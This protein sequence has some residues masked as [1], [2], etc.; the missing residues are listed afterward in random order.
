MKV[1]LVRLILFLVSACA[2]IPYAAHAADPNG[3]LYIA[4]AVP[5]RNISSTTNPEYPVDI[6]IGGHCVVQGLTFGEIR[7][8][9][10][11]PA[12]TYSASIS[13]ADSANPCGAAS[14]TGSVT[15]TA[16]T[17]TL[18]F[19][20]LNSSNQITGSTVTINLHTPAGRG[21]A[22]VVNTTPDNLTATLTEGD[23]THSNP[24]NAPISAGAAV[25]LSLIPGEYRLTIYP[26]GSSTV[27][28]GPKEFDVDSR[29][30][31]LIVFAGKTANESVQI[32]GPKEIKDVL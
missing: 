21:G 20:G 12:G 3:Y 25:P 5:G 2:V 11:F 22:L 30:F 17:S 29:N 27:A 32:V 9:Y 16:G 23:T 26:Q 1:R 4:H 13:I 28:T 24:L 7:G 15:L 31:Y 10:T 18:G 6:S 8:P 19:V 14:F